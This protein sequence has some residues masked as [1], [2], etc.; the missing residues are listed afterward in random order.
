MT[1]DGKL[2]GQQR[3]SWI[4]DWSKALVWCGWEIPQCESGLGML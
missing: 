3:G 1:L 4:P 2:S